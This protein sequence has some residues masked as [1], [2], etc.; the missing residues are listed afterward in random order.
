[1][2]NDTIYKIKIALIYGKRKVDGVLRDGDLEKIY[3]SE[4]DS[5]HYFYIKEFLENH[6]TDENELQA[7]F[8]EKQN[9]NSAFISLHNLGHIVCAEN[10][11]HIDHRSIII[12]LPSNI[13]EN[14]SKTL[15]EFVKQLDNEKYSITFLYHL[16]RDKDGIINGK[17]TTGDSAILDKI[18]HVEHDDFDR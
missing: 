1:M 9:V 18:V 7:V 10:S 6:L 17:Q 16:Y 2:E 11:S 15:N 14:Q 4:E 8:K 5:A 12:Y 3:K 13:T